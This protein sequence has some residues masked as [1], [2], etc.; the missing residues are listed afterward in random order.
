MKK[1]SYYIAAAGVFA[2]F[3]LTESAEA[4]PM[5]TAQTGME[6]AGCH[7]QHM[8]RLNKVGRKFA[9]SGMTMS[10]QVSEMKKTSDMDIH[11]SL[12][13]KSKYTKT[14]DKPDGH[15]FIKEGDTNDGELSPVRMT[16]FYTGGQLTSNIGGILN[17]GWR[18][19]EGRSI[20]GK[21]VY[22]QEL[23]EGYWGAAFYSTA[24]LGP[25]SGMEF[26]NTGLYK[27]LR[28]FDNK[29]YSNANQ[30]TKIGTKA[31][32]GIQ[33]YYDRDNFLTD[34]DHFFITAGIYTPG[35]DNRDLK[36][37]DNILPFARVAYE[38]PI[39]D[40]NVMIGAFIIS[41]G[42]TVSPT[43]PLSI[44]RETFGIDMQV[45]GEIAER[46]VVLTITNIFKNKVE[47]TGIGMQ[48]TDDTEDIENDAFSAEGSISVT[49]SI[50]AKVGYMYFNDRFDYRYNGIGGGT[51]EGTGDLK[52]DVKDLDYA[53]NIGIDY[54][55]T[56]TN[57]PMKIAVEYAWMNPRLD[58]VEEYQSF[59]VTITLPL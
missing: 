27:P 42:E 44:K 46:E 58:R 5:F 50:V 41:G 10:R 21:V 29:V 37:S 3:G 36:M 48:L 56:I 26:Y 57:T 53:I 43:E 35:Q 8:P 51:G 1:N 14:W 38:Y 32:T 40:Y 25:F 47:F 18:K 19:E 12:L 39:G 24:T 45:E 7:T 30:S 22:A 33:A 54:G 20:S 49:P 13:I 6:C 16:T 4:L 15:G 55:F 23:E 11:P 34:G 59:M 31:A 2:V 28:T 9:A 52:P 17:L